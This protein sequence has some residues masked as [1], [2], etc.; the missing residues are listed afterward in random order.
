MEFK[1]AMRTWNRMCKTLG[2]G[3]EECPLERLCSGGLREYPEEAEAIL[4]KWEEGHPGKTRMDDFIEK[5]PHAPKCGD[6]TPKIC[7]YHCGYCAECLLGRGVESCFECWR[8]PLEEAHHDKT[9]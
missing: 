9:V 6:S 3:C 2:D 8:E 7:A 5:H 1:E 4:A